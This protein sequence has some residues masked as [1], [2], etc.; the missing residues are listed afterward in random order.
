V[1]TEERG[2]CPE[3][4]HG[5]LSA[6]LPIGLLVE[7]RLTERHVGWHRSA[8]GSLIWGGKLTAEERARAAELRERCQPPRHAMPHKGCV[9]R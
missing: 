4:W 2:T 6:E 8:D 7:C 1:S 3:A 5:G 9:L